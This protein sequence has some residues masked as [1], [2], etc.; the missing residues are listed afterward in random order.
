MQV[1]CV[2]SELTCIALH[3]NNGTNPKGPAPHVL[4]SYPEPGDEATHVSF[5]DRGEVWVLESIPCMAHKYGNIKARY[6]KL[7]G[8]ISTTFD[9]RVGGNVFGHGGGGGGLKTRTGVMHYSQNHQTQ[10]YMSGIT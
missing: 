9:K 7:M 8:R 4:A 10:A 1:V 3:T 6:L 5:V 2:H